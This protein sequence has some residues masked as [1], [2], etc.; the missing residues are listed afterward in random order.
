MTEEGGSGVRRTITRVRSDAELRSA[1][2]GGDVCYA[3]HVLAEQA[4]G[5]LR[6]RGDGRCT[7]VNPRCQDLD[8]AIKLLECYADGLDERY[9]IIFSP[10]HTDGVPNGRFYDTPV[11]GPGKAVAGY[12]SRTRPRR[13]KATSASIRTTL[14][15]SEQLLAHKEEYAWGSRLP[16]RRSLYHLTS[17]SVRT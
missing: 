4:C 9:Q 5:L 13:T 1:V 16:R 2:R 6:Q 11:S 12:A 7:F 8:E 17:T 14:P 15:T 10:E 3:L